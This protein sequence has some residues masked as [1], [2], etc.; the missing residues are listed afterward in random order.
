MVAAQVIANDVAVTLGG[1]GGMLEMN[2][3]KPLMIENLLQSIR[4]L[5][6][7]CHHFRVF[8]VEGME[9]NRPQIAHFVEQSLMLVTAL[10]PVIGYDQA[11]KVAH[12]AH[13]HHLSLREA[14]LE[15]GVIDAETFDRVV[16]PA[17]MV[18]P[19]ENNKI[20]ERFF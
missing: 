5:S 15:L 20:I 6:D 1:S 3:Y 14:A 8:L 19:Q 18:C 11:S 17:K 12:H 7:G 4:L 13:A 9:P 10:S 2:V 16:D